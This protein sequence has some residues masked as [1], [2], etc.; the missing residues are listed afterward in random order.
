M[1]FEGDVYRWRAREQDWFF[2]ALPVELSE[3]IREIPR[4]PRGFG[5]IPVTARIGDFEWRTSIFPDSAQGTFVLPL[6]KAAR[7]AGALAEGDVAVLAL[8]L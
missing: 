6:K 5:S 8:I 2:V 1:E 4:P 7:D 3:M